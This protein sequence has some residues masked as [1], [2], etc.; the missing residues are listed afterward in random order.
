MSDTDAIESKPPSAIGN[1]A[2]PAP[3]EGL[4]GPGQVQV[5][6][7]EVARVGLMFLQRVDFR[8]HERLAFDQLEAML[9]AIVNGELVVVRP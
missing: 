5:N 8:R 1:G 9:G 7:V 3:G 4:P 2:L 6:P